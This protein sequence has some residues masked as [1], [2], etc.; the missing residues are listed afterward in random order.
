MTG[1]TYNTSYIYAS[2]VLLLVIMALFTANY[3]KVKMPRQGKLFLAICSLQMMSNIFDILMYSDLLL[4]C[5]NPQFAIKIDTTLYFIVHNL[6]PYVYYLYARTYTQGLSRSRHNPMLFIPLIFSLL[7][8]IITPFTGFVFNVD[9]NGIYSRNIGIYFLYL[10]SAI[11]FA[12]SFNILRRTKNILRNRLRIALQ[13]EFIIIAILS[14]LVQAVFYSLIIEGFGLAITLLIIYL[15]VESPEKIIDSDTGAFQSQVFFRDVA[16]TMVNKKEFTV[17]T[18]TMNSQELLIKTFGSELINELRYNVM[19]CLKQLCKQEIIVYHLTDSSFCIAFLTNDEEKIKEDITKVLER[20]DSLFKVKMIE[21][22]VETICCLFKC[23]EYANNADDIL[24]CVAYIEKGNVSYTSGLVYAN[25]LEWHLERENI[26]IR[27]AIQLALR[28]GGFEVYYQPIFSQKTKKVE[29]AEALLRL[30]DPTLGNIPPDRFIPIAEQD[31]SIIEI[32]DYVIEEVCRFISSENIEKYGIRYIEI[33]LSAVQ[34]MSGELV[35]TV[36]KCLDKYNIKREMINLEITE[37][38]AVKS[39][40]MFTR[41][42]EKLANEKITFSLDDYGTGYSTIDYIVSH[43]FKLIK[44]DKSIVASASESEK[45]RIA[46]DS[47][48]AMLQRLNL[49]IVA[50]GVETEEQVKYLSQLGVTHLQGF[51]FSKPVPSQVFLESLKM[52]CGNL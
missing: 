36:L 24:R 39:T 33:N 23:P 2:S 48:V 49:E 6:E 31:G 30:K 8:I 42:I 11:F 27:D 12:L 25:Q 47:T 22:Y 15:S 40:K 32:G 1:N 41:T 44:I 13:Y 28:E 43:P 17:L 46:L 35:P 52:N 51:Y 9:A 50:E 38:A 16:L 19:Q 3:R 20:L 29:S 14:V 26:Q 10:S 5:A 7:C 21:T 4:K 45:A 34:C 18:V 37:T